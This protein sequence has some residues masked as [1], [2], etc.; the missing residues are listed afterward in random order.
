MRYQMKQR[1]WTLGEKFTIKDETGQD[2]F[3]VEGKI[4]SLGDKLSFCS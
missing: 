2:V 3:F 4:L 1:L